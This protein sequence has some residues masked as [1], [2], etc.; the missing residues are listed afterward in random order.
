MDK[1]LKSRMQLLYL[2]HLILIAFTEIFLEK[3]RFALLF[4]PHHFSVHHQVRECWGLARLSCYSLAGPVPDSRVKA[5]FPL[6][7]P[8]LPCAVTPV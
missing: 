8:A 1:S 7:V 5:L 4:T 2:T 3:L 6:Q